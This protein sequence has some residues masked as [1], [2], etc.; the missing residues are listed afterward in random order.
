[1]NNILLEVAQTRPSNFMV[2]SDLIS[3]FYM[4]P[5]WKSKQSKGQLISKCLLVSL[6]GPKNNENIVRISAL[7][8]FKASMGLP[9]GFLGLLVGF[10]SLLMILLT[11]LGSPK[12]LQE[13][14]RKLQRKFQGRNPYNVLVAIL[15][16]T[17][18]LKRHFEINWPL[19]KNSFTEL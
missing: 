17:M 1:M 16:E 19:K 12:K 6:F 10:L 3:D 8:V 18:T 4:I 11:Y 14:P 2:I 15:V 13:S 7:K 9:G 5:I